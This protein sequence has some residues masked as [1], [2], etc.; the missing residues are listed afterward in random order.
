MVRVPGG[1]LR[2]GDQSE[3]CE[4]PIPTFY[5]QQGVV[6]NQEF[7]RFIKAAKYE[8]EPGMSR[9]EADGGWHHHR[10]LTW[11]TVASSSRAHEKHPV[12]GVSWN[13]ASAYCHYFNMRLPTADEWRYAANAGATTP[14]W[15][16]N[17][18]PR[19]RKVGNFADA[20]LLR[21]YPK[22][23]EYGVISGY[24]DGYPK[25]SPSGKFPPNNWGLYDIIGNVWQWVQGESCQEPLKP[26]RGGAWS[27]FEEYLGTTHQNCIRGNLRSDDVG[28]RCAS[29]IYIVK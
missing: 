15:W 3:A 4:R 29:D 11:R 14:Y 23:A 6:T 27:G 18:I 1:C 20:S 5:L 9:L 10:G 12:V 22:F 17:K 24:D 13:D 7:A 26:R 8:M 16:G 21:E 2:T 19:F 28:F 25:T